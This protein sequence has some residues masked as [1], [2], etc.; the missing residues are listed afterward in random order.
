[1]KFRCQSR[2]RRTS[3]RWCATTSPRWRG[4]APDADPDAPYAYFDLYWSEPETRWPFWLR[5]DGANAGFALVRK[6]GP[7]G[8]T[9]IAEFYVAPAYRRKGVGLAAARHVIARF[10]GQW[11]I[12]QRELNASGIAF[13]HRVLDGFV[14]Y[15]EATTHTDAVRR[16][17]TFAYP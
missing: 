2:I 6:E 14:S 9:Q 11:Q 17:Q 15:D 5:A 10:P 3:R 13:W 8:R 16:E 1:M 7:S 4:I 12:T